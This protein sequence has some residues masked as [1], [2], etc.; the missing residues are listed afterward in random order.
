VSIIFGPIHSR[1]FGKSL[2]IDLSP[3]IK[4]CNYDCVYCEL[5]PTQT[6]DKQTDAV[7]VDT[8]ME[9][10]ESAL[11]AHTDIDVLT[12]TANGEPTLYP[13]L[14]EL[15]DRINA[16]KG[17]TRT[18]ILSNGS[19]IA[20][21]AIQDALAKIDTVKLSLDCATSRCFKRID[22]MHEGIDIETI[23]EG[24]LTFRA[25]SSHP[26][27]IEILIVQGIN[28]KPNEIQALNDYLLRLRPDRIDLGTIDR[29]PAYDVQA[30]SYE[31]LLELSLLFDPALPVHIAYR[32]NAT[33][34]PASYDDIAILDT[35]AKRPL[36][37]EDIAIL[38]DAQSQKR[39]EALV[40]SG[41]ITPVEANGVVFFKIPSNNH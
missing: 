17:D 5:A 30:V 25:H 38:F 41:Q 3:N 33:A 1:R 10:I 14:N 27:I 39:L 36:S 23:Q 34:S 9:A 40:Q 2:G 4:Q 26:L 21:P 20:D 19:T 35:L 18:L 16:I 22:R 29:P 7:P 8:I 6:T 11:H 28:D 24:M 37:P 31:R 13:Y 15:I 32:K 12:L